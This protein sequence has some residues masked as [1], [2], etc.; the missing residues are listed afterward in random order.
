MAGRAGGV[1]ATEAHVA[2]CFDALAHHYDGGGA[3]L[4]PPE[5]P[6]GSWCVP[7]GRSG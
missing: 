3:P 6:E 7:A 4:P 5:F 1:R 2:A